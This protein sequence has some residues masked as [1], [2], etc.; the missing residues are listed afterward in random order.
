MAKQVLKPIA[1]EACER[2]E[3]TQ[4][5][6]QSHHRSLAVTPHCGSFHNGPVM[7]TLN[8]AIMEYPR[9]GDLLYVLMPLL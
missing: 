8:K 2:P 4:S 9:K 6:F 7:F 5:L 1:D 3:N